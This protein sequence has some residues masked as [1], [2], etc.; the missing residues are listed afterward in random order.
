VDEMQKVLSALDGYP[1]GATLPLLVGAHG[2]TRR[3]IK[4]CLKQNYT[5]G[6]AEN[7]WGTDIMRLWITQ[8]GRRALAGSGRVLR[9]AGRAAED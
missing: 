7:V 6:C 3:A 8:A 2:C 1:G 5:Y 4:Q 9:N